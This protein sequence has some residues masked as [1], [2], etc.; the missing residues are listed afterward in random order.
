M[1]RKLNLDAL[2]VTASILCAIHCAVLPL[3][4]ASLPILGVNIL[5]NVFFEY[6]MIALAFFIGTT[7]LWHG[8]S[9]HHHRLTPWLLFV[10]G[11]SCLITKEIW[12]N[13]ELG[14]LPFAV[15]LVV[16]A[17]W[18]NY[19]LCRRHHRHHRHS[20][21]DPALQIPARRPAASPRQ[22]P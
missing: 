8:F 7:A 22:V 21:H 10:A 20:A 16:G 12:S 2:G 4:V 18:F 6:S 14:I 1:F 15:L 13:Y 5:H 19:R 9:H 3:V 17:H 11:I